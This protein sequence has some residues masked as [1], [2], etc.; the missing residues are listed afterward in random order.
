ME[1][2]LRNITLQLVDECD[3]NRYDAICRA[4]KADPLRGENWLERMTIANIHL[5][6]AVLTEPSVPAEEIWPKLRP[7]DL[8]KIATAI[9]ALVS[10]GDEENPTVSEHG[11][12]SMPGSAEPIL[13]N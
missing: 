4:Y 8:P 2:K 10:G 1:L 3:L 13:L 11:S 6:L 12:A 7:G 9:T 5:A